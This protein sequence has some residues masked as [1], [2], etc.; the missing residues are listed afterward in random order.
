MIPTQGK[1]YYIDYVDNAQPEGSYYGIAKFV[2]AYE[3]DE[4]GNNLKIPLYEFEHP[5][6][7]GKMVLSLFT[8]E[9]II[10]EAK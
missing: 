2:R 7:D 1:F 6:K 10:L 3:R 5:D 8:K 9:E 4:D